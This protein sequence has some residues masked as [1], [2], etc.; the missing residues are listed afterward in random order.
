MARRGFLVMHDFHNRIIAW[1]SSTP[2]P[3]WLVAYGYLLSQFLSPYY[4]H[5]ERWSAGQ[6]QPSGCQSEN[7]RFGP[8]LS[9]KGV[10]STLKQAP[11]LG[12]YCRGHQP[13]GHRH[14]NAAFFLTTGLFCFPLGRLSNHADRKNILWVECCPSTLLHQTP[15]EVDYDR[16][17][18]IY[19][20]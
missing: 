14:I 20:R 9:G 7:A 5:R 15:R 10:F 13:H 12:R 16:R 4:N 1:A 8:T 3:R 6:R 11:V 2:L 19:P 17:K 18:K